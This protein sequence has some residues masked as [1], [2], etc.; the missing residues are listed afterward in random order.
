MLFTEPIALLKSLYGAYTLAVFYLFYV[1]YPY[2]LTRIYGFG[3]KQCDL[4]YISLA[5]GSLLAIVV[6][7]VVDKTLYQKAKS[8]AL[9]GRLPPE[10]RMYG[11]MVASILLPVSLFW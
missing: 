8:K 9:D 10:A 7:G 11:A 6:V 1:A 3:L 5:M 4:A 2:V